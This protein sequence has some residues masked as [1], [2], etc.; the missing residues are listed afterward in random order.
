M[1]T[2]G[3]W[4]HAEQVGCA[5]NGNRGETPP[6]GQTTFKTA[7]FDR[8]ATSPRGEI[9]QSETIP[10]RV[11]PAMYPAP[12]PKHQRTSERQLGSDAKVE[13]LAQRLRDRVLGGVPGRANKIA[14]HRTL[15]NAAYLPYS[16]HAAPAARGFAPERPALLQ[17]GANPSRLSHPGPNARIHRDR[18][19]RKM[20]SQARREKLS[21]P[22]RHRTL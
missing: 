21:K 8:S 19:Q 9:G 11:Y 15:Q 6:N 3:C 12:D 4:I 10:D 2:H 14:T 1:M 7:A 22:M 13:V 16:L 5:S 20:K 18:S 17:S